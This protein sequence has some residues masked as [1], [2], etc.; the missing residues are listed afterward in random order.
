[1]FVLKGKNFLHL[2][3]RDR[4]RVELNLFRM[5][6]KKVLFRQPKGAKFS[7]FLGQVSM[8]WLLVLP[9]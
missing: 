2:S 5:F 1:M 3:E 4:L 6:L 9:C 7:F 8:C